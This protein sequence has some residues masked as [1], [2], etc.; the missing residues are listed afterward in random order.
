MKFQLAGI[1]A[2]SLFAMGSAFAG[3]IYTY[4]VSN[5]GQQSAAGTIDYLAVIYDEEREHL[6]FTLE[7]TR[8]TT[9][10]D[11]GWF[12]LSPGP[13]P[14]NSATELAIFYLDFAGGDIYTYRYNGIPGQRST[15]SASYLD[16]SAF[17]GS[18]QDVLSVDT[19]ADGLAVSFNDLDI[20]SIA[21]GTFGPDWTGATFGEMFGGW[22]HFAAL[23]AFA[24]TDGKITTFSPS[25]QTWLDVADQQTEVPEPVGLG[26]AALAGVGA[27]VLYRQR[28]RNTTA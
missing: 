27:L 25:L 14:K 4:S 7:L 16:H 22:F 17:I 8:S 3:P 19:T 1:A 26:L 20:S 6:D 13:D 10:A 9:L 5:P 28:R 24:I 2:A 21:P 18:Y 12:V 15:G 11:A 23:D